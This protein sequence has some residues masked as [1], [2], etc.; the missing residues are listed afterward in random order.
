M[1]TWLKIKWIFAYLHNLPRVLLNSALWRLGYW[2]PNLLLAAWAH[3][4]NAFIG[5]FTWVLRFSSLKI[6]EI[7]VGG[8][9]KA[10][11]MD[12]RRPI[13]PFFIKIHNLGRYSSVP[14]RSAWHACLSIVR[15]K[16]PLH[17]LIWVCMF[18]DFEKQSHHCTFIG[19]GPV[20]I[21]QTSFLAILPCL[22]VVW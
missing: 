18:I 21:R 3:T 4:M 8:A 10:K 12:Y 14:N 13:K 15:K 19:I 1:C 11:T 5:R 7:I 9:S 17:S 6:K 2:S 22:G 20:Q 16:S